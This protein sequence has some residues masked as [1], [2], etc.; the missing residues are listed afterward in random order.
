MKPW[1]TIRKTIKDGNSQEGV[2]EFMTALI[3]GIPA[4]VLSDVSWKAPL[5]VGQKALIRRVR[6]SNIGD[7]W[8]DSYDFCA[9]LLVSTS[10]SYS[11]VLLPSKDDGYIT[12]FS[13]VNKLLKD[14][15]DGG[16]IRTKTTLGRFLTRFSTLS[17]VEIKTLTEKYNAKFKKECLFLIPNT[18]PDGWE[19]VYENSLG[20][21]SCMMYNNPNSRCLNELCHGEYHP[22]RA[23]A[24]PE[25]DL[26]LAYMANKEWSATG[27]E[28]FRVYARAIVNVK[29]KT[30]LRVYGDDSMSHL[31]ESM[32]YKRDDSTIDGQ[33]LV[34]LMLND[35]EIVCPYLD[36]D[37][38]QIEDRED[39]LLIVNRGL[40]TSS[41]G[42]IRLKWTCPHCGHS[43]ADEDAIFS[44]D[45][46][47]DLRCNECVN[48]SHVWGYSRYG[49]GW[50]EME[51]AIF[52]EDE[53][54]T[55][56]S[57][58]RLGY[59]YSPESGEWVHESDGAFTSRGLMRFTDPN[60][61]DLAL[62]DPD[63]NDYA[64]VDDTISAW[65]GDGVEY[66]VHEDTD[67]FNNGLSDTNPL[68]EENE[69]GK[70]S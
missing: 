55:E 61:V 56:G 59:H 35:E 60:I 49:E 39:H 42:L 52:I 6:Y 33:K 41:N 51:S 53:Y 25:N 7:W 14:N 70:A 40:E 34:R 27:S 23:Y 17:D 8:S 11:H 32:G 29:D 67:L 28:R 18:N 54:Y 13:S 57:A 3:S 22:V 45:N 69:N 26:S 48:D 12:Y 10:F 50:I 1:Q 66:I 4:N 24:H 44:V 15:Q 64:H 68:D 31:L 58:E 38:N 65:N 2:L 37:N 16:G 20:F 62:P 19:A 30:Y 46:N 36:G 9:Q 43:H 63:G 47:N 21:S 5:M